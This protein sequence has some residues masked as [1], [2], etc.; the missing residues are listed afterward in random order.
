MTTLRELITTDCRNK[1]S[2][3]NPKEKKSWKPRKRL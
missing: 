2:N 3:E 1:P